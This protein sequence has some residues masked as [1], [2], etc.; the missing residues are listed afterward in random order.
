MLQVGWRSRTICVLATP[1]DLCRWCLP[2]PTRRLGWKRSEHQQLIWGFEMSGPPSQRA[3]NFRNM[4]RG[5]FDWTGVPKP[6]PGISGFSVAEVAKHYDDTTC[7]YI[8]STGPFIQAFRGHD[9]DALM[10]HYVERFSLSDGMTVL[11]AG[12]GVAAPAIWLAKRFPN[13]KIECLTNSSVQAEI[14]RSRIHEADLTGRLSVTLG[15]FHRLSES[16]APGVFDRALF[17][18]TLNHSYCIDSVLAGLHVVMK[19]G[20]RACIKDFFRRRASDRRLQAELDGVVRILNE[21]YRYNAGN[22]SDLIESCMENGFLIG[23]VSPPCFES[24]FSIMM[25]FEMDHGFETYTALARV[26]AIDWY[27]VVA[28]RE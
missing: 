16:F 25:K 11:D 9:T 4:V 15:D 8:H 5:L 20:G 14:A 6:D 17:L 2:R 23:S 26:H 7:K 12:C 10:E 3:S 13:I 19:R 21:S 28:I 18:E 22:L 24:D 1:R 27:E